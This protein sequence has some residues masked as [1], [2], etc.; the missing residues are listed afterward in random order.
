MNDN[1]ETLYAYL[2]VDWE[3]ED[4]VCVAEDMHGAQVLW[5]DM[6]N[7]IRDP[8]SVTIL[9]REPVLVST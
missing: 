2:I 6:T 7:V 5:H 4:Q 3:W 9:S 1:D 8:D